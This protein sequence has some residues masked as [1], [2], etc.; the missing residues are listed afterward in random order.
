MELILSLAFLFNLIMA[1]LK[2]FGVWDPLTWEI[3]YWMLVVILFV[4][5][6]V[7]AGND[8]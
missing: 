8:E 2:A 5:Y 1:A 4:T 7:G 6:G 3:T